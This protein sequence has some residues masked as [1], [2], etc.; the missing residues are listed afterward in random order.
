VVT[1]GLSGIF[2]KGLLVGTINRVYR[3]RHEL[4]QSADIEPVVDFNQVEW[5][6]VMLR[7]PKDEEYPQFTN[8]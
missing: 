8:P 6:F 5:V 2:P 3:E 7:D 1:S 4:F